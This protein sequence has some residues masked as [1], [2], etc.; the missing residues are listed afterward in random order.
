[1]LLN[2]PLYLL[3]FVCFFITS[4]S[5]CTNHVNSRV[6]S[7]AVFDKLLVPETV[8]VAAGVYVA[9]SDSAER[10]YAYSLDESAYGHDRT[11]RGGWYDGERQ[12]QE[13]HV[14]SFE[15]SLTP[16]TNQQYAQFVQKTHHRPPD[17]DRE[18]WR[19]YGLIHPFER[20]RKFAWING[21]PPIGREQHP[22]VLVSFTDAQAYAEWL[23]KQTGHQWS[24]PNEDQWE[25][26][27]RGTRGLRFP[28]GNA[29][30]ASM[31]NSHD[32]GPFDTVAVGSFGDSQSEYGVVD[33]AGQVFEWTSVQTDQ[34]SVMVKGGS[35]DDSGCGV[36]RPAASHYRPAHLRHILIGFRL[37]K[38]PRQK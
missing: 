31:L 25:K 10:E 21:Q 4:N 15:I 6:N 38:L 33:G 26:A 2:A 1:M 7:K 16:V 35:W 32:A 8:V 30:D 13:I 12:R 18:T 28:W 5:G 34:A 11:R 29:F 22:V 20:T 37:L 14:D 24:L 17:V 9:G 27:I 23:T 19:S 36:C 3:I